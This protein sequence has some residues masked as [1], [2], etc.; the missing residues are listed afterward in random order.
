MQIQIASESKY[1]WAQ[2]SSFKIGTK[3]KFKLQ[4][5]PSIFE[6]RNPLLN[7]SQMQIQIASKSKYIW[8]QKSLFQIEAKLKFKCNFKL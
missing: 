3:C 5:N 1:I 2:K 4:A 7:W 8:A 6:H